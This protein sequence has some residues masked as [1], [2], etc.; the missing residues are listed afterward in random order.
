MKNQLKTILLL[1]VLSALL[2]AIGGAL[3][4]TYLYL[5][6]AISLVMNLGAYFYSDRIVLRMHHA[7]EV[8]PTEAP[9]L[10]RMVADLARRAEIPMPRVFIIPDEQPN[11]FAT[12][13]NPA[14]GVVAVT[15]GILSLL[16]E[17]ELR[18]V[19]AHELGHVKNRDVLL[20]TIAAAT[21]SM[22]TY[23]AHAVGYSALFGGGDDEDGPGG[24]ILLALLAPFAAM[25]IQLG[26]SR[27]REF[28]ADET[29]ARIAG[30]TDGLARALLKLEHGARVIPPATAQPATA[31][32]F[33][34]N[35][36]AGGASLTK[37]FSTH[38]P[39]EARV[40]RLRELR[41]EDSP[42]RALR[43]RM[44]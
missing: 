6:A 21:A 40:A 35:P 38:P 7:R 3:G 23:A 43:R 36:L 39:T 20:S 11:A 15:E 44:A 1:G 32:L 19:L 41:L 14:H 9:G 22:I 12:G 26:I 2:I 16:D 34:V 5:F 29:G 25:L 18:G 4:T 31:S 10:H 42:P 30:D 33:I 17:R 24:G 8:T 27:S 28:H 37:L 13:R